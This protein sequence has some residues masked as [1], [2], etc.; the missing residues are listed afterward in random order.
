MVVVVVVVVVM[1]VSLMICSRSVVDVYTQDTSR[2]D[3]SLLLYLIVI[4]LEGTV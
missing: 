2:I 3:S 4:L 1:M